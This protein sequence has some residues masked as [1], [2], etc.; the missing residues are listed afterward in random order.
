MTISMLANAAVVSPLKYGSK[1]SRLFTTL[2]LTSRIPGSG[3]VYSYWVHERA[4][5]A[6]DKIMPFR[7]GGARETRDI[8]TLILRVY[9][10]R[11]FR[12][13]TERRPSLHFNQ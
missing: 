1:S 4:R 7:Q 12:S 3:E 2:S 10:S 13:E 8:G 6:T 5:A 9:V 11:N